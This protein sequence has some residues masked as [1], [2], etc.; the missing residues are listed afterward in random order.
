MKETVVT[1]EREPLETVPGHE[2][3]CVN[4]LVCRIC[5][6]NTV[7]EPLISPCNCKGTLAHVHLTC[8]ERWLNETSRNY[9][10]LC[11]FRFNAIQ[12]PRYTFWQSVRM[13]VKHP[14]NR[15]HVQSDML[16][17]VLLTIVTAGLITVCLLGMQ[18]F[19]LEGSKLGISQSWTRSAISM[20]LTVIVMGYLITLYLV[21][22]D[23]VVPWYNWWKNTVD[24]RLLL[25]P[26][27]TTVTRRSCRETSV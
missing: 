21:I 12:T 26:S 9:C 13:W 25:S 24:V 8:L 4:S 5:Q 17:S 14:R 11:M 10:E 19:V 27:L 1:K 15:S 6:T 16:I 3:Q 23:Q 18:Y 22:K 20:F 2:L 7:Q